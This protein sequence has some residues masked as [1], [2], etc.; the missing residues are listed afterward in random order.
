MASLTSRKFQKHF[1]HTCTV[2]RAT[3]GQN[4]SGELVETYEPH[5]TEQKFRLV[6][7]S[8]SFATPD[9]GFQ[10]AKVSNGFFP[11]DTDIAENLDRITDIKFE[12]GTIL[13]TTRKQDNATENATYTVE[14]VFPRRTRV[15]N[16]L[17]VG[18]QKIN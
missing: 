3:R 4:E 14:H 15:L 2:L 13:Q 12:D 11:P 8:E 7:K 17:S 1:I 18:L 16:H 6:E 10:R 5:L 9:E